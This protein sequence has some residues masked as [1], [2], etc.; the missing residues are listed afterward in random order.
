M[1]EVPKLH[2]SA[3]TDTI[4]TSNLSV[5]A[6]FKQH[7]FSHTCLDRTCKSRGVHAA[8]LTYKLTF[9]VTMRRLLIICCLSFMRHNQ[10]FR[11]QMSFLNN[12]FYIQYIS[13]QQQT[14]SSCSV[15]MKTNCSF[16]TMLSCL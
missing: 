8:P 9:T 2:F 12:Q 6:S 14:G 13:I 1:R 10:I 3:D 16:T 4:I 15:S 5:T 11:D 7:K